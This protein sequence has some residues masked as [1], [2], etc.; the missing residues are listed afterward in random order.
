MLTL[1]TCGNT[2]GN[3]LTGNINASSIREVWDGINDKICCPYND[4]KLTRNFLGE[5]WDTHYV[6]AGGVC[7]GGT[8]PQSYASCVEKLA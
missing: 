3:L 4:T 1:N 8:N 5:V 2:G 6:K 7:T